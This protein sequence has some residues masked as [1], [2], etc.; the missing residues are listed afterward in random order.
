MLLCWYAGVYLLGLLI[1]MTMTS[2]RGVA[3]GDSII[4]QSFYFEGGKRKLF[5]TRGSRSQ[6]DPV[7]QVGY[8]P[9]L[10]A[11]RLQVLRAAW[12]SGTSGCDANIHL[13]NRW[14]LV[15]SVLIR[16]VFVLSGM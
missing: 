3:E 13:L 8:L 2:Q 16:N 6:V 12:S 11:F 14:S 5:T 1:Y 4:L 9:S 7:E 15:S 10:P